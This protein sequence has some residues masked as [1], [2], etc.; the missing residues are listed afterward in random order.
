MN[1]LLSIFLLI[2]CILCKIIIGFSRTGR[3]GGGI[4]RIILIPI[5]PLAKSISVYTKTT[6]E[7]AYFVVEK[8]YET[9]L[10]I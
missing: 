8:S 5:F 7:N 10:Q 3:G 1:L 4:E 2:Y 6:R 9:I